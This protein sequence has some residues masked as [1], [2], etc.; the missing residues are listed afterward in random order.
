MPSWDRHLP[1]LHLPNDS[2]IKPGFEV[3]AIGYTRC[4]HSL[5]SCKLPKLEMGDVTKNLALEKKKKYHCQRPPF[6]LL[7]RNLKLRFGYFLRSPKAILMYYWNRTTASFQ[8]V[9]HQASQRAALL[10][11]MERINLKSS[12]QVIKVWMKKN[13]ILNIIPE[14]AERLPVS[15]KP[16]NLQ[17]GRAFN[18]KTQGRR[19]GWDDL[20]E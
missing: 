6:D 14:T 4:D 11:Y 18:I 10:P 1:R 16:P 17:I 8:W 15:L 9:Y 7:R 3:K 2:H 19:W 20:R 5:Q 13:T 12:K